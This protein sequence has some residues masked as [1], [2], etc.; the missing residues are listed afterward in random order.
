[1]NK[2]GLSTIVIIIILV[3]VFILLVAIFLAP[4]GL[5]QKAAEESGGILQYLPGKE[6]PVVGEVEVPKEIEDRFEFFIGVIETYVES[7][8]E[9]LVSYVDFDLEE[10][11]IKLTRLEDRLVL[12]LINEKGQEV[13]TRELSGLKICVV[14]GTIDGKAVAENFY[15][16]HILKIPYVEEE[17][18]DEVDEIVLTSDDELV[19]DNEEKSRA[20]GYLYKPD[21][22]HFCF[23]PVW[24]TISPFDADYD[25][26][27]FHSS[28]VD[29]FSAVQRCRAP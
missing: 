26:D 22:E 1:M 12:K 24:N 11:K 5:L 29:K 2:K 15:N 3:I 9:C 10:N 8:G 14:A 7:E 28:M 16:K 27:G 6:E 23:F 19:W 21:K 20:K 17:Y 4:G 25:E 18:N 13:K